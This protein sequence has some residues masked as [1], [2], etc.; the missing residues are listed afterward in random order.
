LPSYRSPIVKVVLASAAIGAL[1]AW[2]TTREA[3]ESPTVPPH[4]AGRPA[5]APPAARAAP[6][7]FYLLA[8]TVHAAFCADGHR[9]LGECQ[10]AAAW[11]LVIHGLWPENR[12]PGTYP[13]DC[14]APPLALE[15]ALRT[16]LE[17]YMP[18]MSA[19]LEAHE[20]REHGGCTGLDGDAYFARALELTRAV[21]SALAARLTTLA[22]GDADAPTLRAAAELFR[23][24]I[25]ATLTLHC[26]MVRVAPRDTRP[27]PY[28]VE[29]RQCVRR[30]A[31]GSPGAPFDCASVGRRDQGCG[32]S[33]H[34]AAARE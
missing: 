28:L 15:P 29:V 20:W 32:R 6:F 11:P 14:P 4:R 8:L 26:R 17:P 19:N 27:V 7:E 1:F 21:E 31:D 25:G 10:S 24:G 12:E 30:E 18:G 22:G 13:H 34:I 5:A 2:H 23:P 9:Q 3:A 16:E 33:F